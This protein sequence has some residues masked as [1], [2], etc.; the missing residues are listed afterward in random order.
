MALA[1][2]AP[3]HPVDV[4]LPPKTPFPSGTEPSSWRITR[5]GF[6]TCTASWR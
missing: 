2:E 1:E 3:A 5:R 6:G 4:F